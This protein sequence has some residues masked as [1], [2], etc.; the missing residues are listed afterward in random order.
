M[1]SEVSSTAEA[2]VMPALFTSTS[3]GSRRAGSVAKASAAES[4]AVDVERDR[5]HLVEARRRQAASAMASR[6]SGSTRAGVHAM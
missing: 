3:T 5:V 4:S 1:S 2:P 6:P